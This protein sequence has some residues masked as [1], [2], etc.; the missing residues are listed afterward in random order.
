MESNQSNQSNQSNHH[1]DDK[2]PARKP[3]LKCH[4]CR[5]K[6]KMIHFTCKCGKLFCIS[7]HNPHSHNCNYDYKKERSEEITLNNPKLASKLQ[8]I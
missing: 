3:T 2:K 4:E 6:L 8:K 1:I 7:H 5:K